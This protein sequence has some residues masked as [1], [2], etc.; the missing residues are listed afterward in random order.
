MGAQGIRLPDRAF[1]DRYLTLLQAAGIKPDQ[2]RWYVL[3]VEQYLKAHP[4]LALADHGPE[5]LGGWFE[6]LGRES[7]LKDWQFLQV[8]EALRWLF[9]DLQQCAWANGFDWQYWRN[10]ARALL[11]EHPT[12][13]RE[14][15]LRGA[16]LVAES[17]LPSTALAS[18]R[19]AGSAAIRRLVTE[20]RRRGY[21]IRTEQAYEQWVVRFVHFSDDRDPSDLGAAE[22][23]RFLEHLAVERTVAVS[24]QNQALNALVFLYSQVLDRPLG[25]LGAF[26]RARRPR[27]LPVVLARA[28]VRALLEAM[29]GTHQLM[30]RLM[31]GT[32]MRLLECVRLRIK[33]IDFDY[34]QI[35]IRDAKGGKDR[36]VPLPDLLPEGLMTHLTRVR[37]LFEEDRAQGFGEVFLPDGLSRKFRGAARD[38][39]WQYAFPSGLLSVDPRS[40]KTRRHHLHENG[41]QRAIKRA[42]HAAGLTKKVS[43]HALRHSFA[44]H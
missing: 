43:S 37:E 41:L 33:D 23:V 29:S 27:R 39:I 40:A 16:R 19:V 26:V 10:S 5:H 13:A 18:A 4:D 44:T 2:A 30:A 11:P 12:L 38:W 3:R 17:G 42:A 22:V 35:V 7:R 25:D 28:Q 9:V 31:Y 20:V 15:G 24:T 36:I 14:Q 34:R 32:G 6:G 21:S 1:W 8:I